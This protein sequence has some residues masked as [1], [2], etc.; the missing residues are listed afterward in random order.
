MSTVVAGMNRCGIVMCSDSKSSVRAENGRVRLDASRLSVKKVFKNDH[1]IIGTWGKNQIYG[2]DRRFHTLEDIL[3][4]ILLDT[5]NTRV[6]LDR[7]H[8][9]INPNVI[10]SGINAE[11]GPYH[12][13]IGEKN[14][15]G[16]YV[17]SEYQFIDKG[18]RFVNCY[19]NPIVVFG[20]I[21]P[22]PIAYS[23]DRC[24]EDFDIPMMKEYV[25]N[26]V[27]Y[28]IQSRELLV[29]LKLAYYSPVGGDIQTEVF[30]C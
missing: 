30:D 21:L 15:N 25:E 2:E 14:G 22:G 26:Y 23:N 9:Q 3:D 20:G 27:K 5:D 1:M 24:V 11:G 16:R 7:L 12:F 17:L 10:C 13:L 29:D 4:E 6:L 19:T 8:R 28:I 18:F